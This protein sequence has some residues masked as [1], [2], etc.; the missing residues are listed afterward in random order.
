MGFSNEQVASLKAKLNPDHVANRSQSGRTL[1]YVEGWHVIAEANRIFG[2]DA[3]DREL[4]SIKLLGEPRLVDGKSRV[5]YMAT[6]RVTV[7]SGDTVTV[8]D[9]TGFGS[10]IDKDVDQAHESA[11][12]EAETDAMKRSLM[13]FGNPFGLA[14]YDKT[15][16][17]VGVEE[18]DVPLDYYGKPIVSGGNYTAKMRAR[19]KGP[20]LSDAGDIN[21]IMDALKANVSGKASADA[22]KSWVE[23]QWNQIKTLPDP[24]YDELMDEIDAERD[25]LS[26]GAAA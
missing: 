24:A 16:A 15:Q 9:G 22:L 3:W 4:V 21:T 20:R 14:L 26:Q 10:G 23:L 17:S 1:S 5:G 7:R 25:R 6:V 13:T 2:F 19:G 18:K 8:R 12:K 11:L